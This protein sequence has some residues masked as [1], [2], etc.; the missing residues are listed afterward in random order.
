[1]PARAGV[2]V[3]SDLHVHTSLGSNDTD[4]ISFAADYAAL[5]VE[6][7]LGLIVLTDHSNCAGSMDCPTGDVE[8]CPNQGPELVGQAEDDGFGR[9]RHVST[10]L[11]G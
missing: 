3:G 2:W 8:D 10:R 1:M 9:G 5:G 6:R 4:G 7:D 11:C